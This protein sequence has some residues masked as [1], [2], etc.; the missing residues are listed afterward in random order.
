MQQTRGF[1]RLAGGP[2]G[3]GAIGIVAV[4]AI[5]A[6]R[7]ARA[8][9]ISAAKAAAN[10]AGERLSSQ[11]LPFRPLLGREQAQQL[12]V[13][14]VTGFL[15]LFAHCFAVAAGGGLEQVAPFVARGGLNIADAAFLFVAQTQGAGHFG[16]GQCLPA[17][18]L[19]GDLLEA[20]ELIL[21]EDRGQRRL[22]GLASL[23][24][25]L[26]PFFATEIA[27]AGK[28]LALFGDLLVDAHDLIIG[29]LE[30]LLNRF[31]AKQEQAP[32][33]S[34]TTL[35]TLGPRPGRGKHHG[36]D[37]KNDTIFPHHSAPIVFL[38]TAAASPIPRRAEVPR[39][40]GDSIR[41]ERSGRRC[42]RRYK[43]RAQPIVPKEMGRIC[44]RALLALSRRKRG[45]KQRWPGPAA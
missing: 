6:A 27:E 16:I 1:G 25:P 12:F 15:D 22:I 4:A 8:A 18:L 30:F 3:A 43:P 5:A 10:F 17:A 42:R 20:L 2:S 37:S 38:E 14:G 45:S 24:E 34:A 31:L 7:A 13:G 26:L 35:G 21:V 36:R 19:E 9:A 29:Q 28:R 33:E 41:A 11:L 32:A 40:R 39:Q 44:N 23:C